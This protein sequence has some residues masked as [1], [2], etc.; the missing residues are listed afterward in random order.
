MVDIICQQLVIYLLCVLLIFVGN[1]SAILVA[2]LQID[3]TRVTVELSNSSSSTPAAYIQVLAVGST[4]IT[5][6]HRSL[7]ATSTLIKVTI[8]PSTNPEDS[9]STSTSITGSI[10]SALSDP[11]NPVNQEM[12]S[13]GI[14]VQSVAVI[15]DT[16]TDS[17]GSGNIYS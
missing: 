5:R 3:P 12:A 4:S 6:H 14:Q 1:I 7:D 10:S 11:E 2:N 13:S 16:P 8:T 17:G 9:S 15:D